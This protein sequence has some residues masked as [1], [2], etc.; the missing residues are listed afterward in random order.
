VRL[1]VTWVTPGRRARSVTRALAVVPAVLIISV[2]GNGSV[3][4]LVNL[5]QVVLCLELPFALFPLLQ[6]TSFRK[7]MGRWRNG[8]FLL[9][10]GWGGAILITAMDLYTL[11]DALRQAWAVIVGH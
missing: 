3:T 8:W 11:P 5:S 4:D 10:T 1:T 6:F 9:L 7:R 2:R